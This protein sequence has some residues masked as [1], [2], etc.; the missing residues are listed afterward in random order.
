MAATQYYKT[1]FGEKYSSMVA[2][3]VE[4]YSDPSYD[5]IRIELKS[6]QKLWR[7]RTDLIEIT[8]TEYQNSKD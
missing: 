6:G 7:Q 1:R 8:E 5:D 4:W 3:A 2:I